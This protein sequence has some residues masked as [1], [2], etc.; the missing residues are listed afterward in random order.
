MKRKWNVIA[1]F[2]VPFFML[3]AGCDKRSPEVVARELAQGE[4]S[5]YC[6]NFHYNPALFDGSMLA[7]DWHGEFEFQ[8]KDRTPGSDFVIL[9]T[10]K[11]GWAEATFLGRDPRS[12]YESR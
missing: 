2:A 9:V 1:L 8:W 3:L 10:V 5:H 6:A 7:S 11:N 4:F 12:G